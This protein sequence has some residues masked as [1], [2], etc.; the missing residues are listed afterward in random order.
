MTS[1]L[2]ADLETTLSTAIEP[3]V[4]VQRVTDR[5]LE[6]MGAADGVM[7]GFADGQ[8]VTYVCG[9]GRSGTRVGTSVAIDASL[10][11]LAVRTGQIQRSDDTQRDPRVDADACRL[12]SVVSLVCVPLSRGHE[13]FGIL[14]VNAS[15]AGAFTCED[16]ATL[17]RVAD[18]VGV[19]IGSA[20]DLHRVSRELL[21]ELDLTSPSSPDARSTTSRGGTASRYVVGVL[22]PDA[23]DRI[24]SSQRIRAILDRPE[25]LSIVVQPIVD[26]GD[27]QV[28]AVE[29]LARFAGP[30]QR[31]PDR[32]FAEAHRCD[33]GVELEVLAVRRALTLLPRLPPCVSLTL[34]AG[35]LTVMSEWFRET[36]SAAPLDRVILELTEHTAIDDYPQL[37]ASLRAL[38]SRGM[39][40]AIDDTGS[41]FSSLAH[42]LKMAPDFIK[43]DRELTTGIDLDPVRR[44][45]AASLVTFAAE[46]GAQII[47]EGIE[48]ED[49]LVTLRQ[50]GVRYGQGYHLGRPASIDA[51]ADRRAQLAPP[52]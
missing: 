40:L 18:F 33:L 22:S 8:T 25:A 41:G 9:S 31:S 2:G 30:P 44:A 23:V 24:D 20:R 1:P 4:L 37:V 27:D 48:T 13:T 51:L 11:G 17:T 39:R 43:L 29:A 14:A 47:A 19:V 3:M 36:V 32:W 34:N 38:R 49:A 26:L 6:L 28:V 46:T 15:T 52:P 50:L 7:V 5:T 45:L 16:I 12:L 21:D 10:S 42:I 35:P